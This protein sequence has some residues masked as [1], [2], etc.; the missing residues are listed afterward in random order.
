MWVLGDEMALEQLFLNLLI[1]AAQALE[2]GGKAGIVVDV[3]GREVRVVV[4]DNGCGIPAPDLERV[5]EPFFSTKS[6]GTGLGLSIA[7][8]ITVAH[9]GTLRI[10]SAPNRETR[11]EVLLPL[12]V[13]PPRA[14]AQ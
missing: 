11:V 6:N 3:V 14:T 4:T 5:L 2:R 12:A 10:E 1:N 8:Q 13:A 7:R 9:G